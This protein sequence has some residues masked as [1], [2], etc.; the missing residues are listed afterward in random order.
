[1]QGALQYDVASLLWQARAGLSAEWKESLLQHYIDEANNLLPTPVSETLFIQ[2]FNGYVLLRLLQVLG[3]YGFRGLFERKA[4]FLTSIPLALRN[5]QWFV[6]NQLHLGI[7]AHEFTRVLGLI[8]KK[9]SSAVLKIYK[10]RGNAI[11]SRSE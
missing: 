9:I 1:M 4:H 6:L 2:R 5:L 3:A 7:E 11:G 10:L 8:V